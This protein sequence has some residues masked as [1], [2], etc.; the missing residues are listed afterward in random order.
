MALKLKTVPK[1]VSPKPWMENIHSTPH[2]TVLT[3]IGSSN[4]FTQACQKISFHFGVQH[5]P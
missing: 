2:I 3:G 4:A 5:E 1:L